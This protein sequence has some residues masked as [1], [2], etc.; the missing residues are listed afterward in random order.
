VAE[1]SSRSSSIEEHQNRTSSPSSRLVIAL[2]CGPVAHTSEQEAHAARID[3]RH[4]TVVKT[5]VT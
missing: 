5:L 4:Y 1:R 3:V 2:P